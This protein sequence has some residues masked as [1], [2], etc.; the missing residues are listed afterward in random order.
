MKIALST[1]AIA[2]TLAT[3]GFAAPAFA[4]DYRNAGGGYDNYGGGYGQ[5][6]GYDCG[7]S[8]RQGASEGAVFGAL[9]GAAFG[10]GVAGRGHHTGGALI[11]AL[12]GAAIGS[13]LGRS[14]TDTQCGDRGAPV[15]Y[16]QT[17][18]NVG[19]RADG[20]RYGWQSDSR[21]DNRG[22]TGYGR[23]D[24]WGGHPRAH[25]NRDDRSS[26][27]GADDDRGR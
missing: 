14:S 17:Y 6:Y 18:R 1:L 7:Q 23:A 22:D 10:S 20:G 5:T 15:R 11:G 21:Y 3:S 24:S 16:E 13:S 2:A 25:A 26:Y 12:T 9:A 19:G 4:Q 8:R 27:F